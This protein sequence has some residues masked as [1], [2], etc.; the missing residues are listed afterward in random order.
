M[1]GATQ[2]SSNNGSTQWSVTFT[3]APGDTLLVGCNFNTGL[4]LAGVAD[5]AGDAFSQIGTEADSSTTA[6]RAYIASNIRGG[7]TTV[8]CATATAA[9]ANDIYVTELRGVDPVH[10]VDTSV[11]TSGT[12]NPARA[13]LAT[14]HANELAWAYVAA[15]HASD[16]SG[17]TALSTFNGN[18]VADHLQTSPGTV[19]PA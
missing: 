3:P 19:I 8:S 12:R 18:L 6:A 11:S 13:S 16:L 4:S 14:S 5:S 9:A 17:W 2:S 1:V 15:G 7:T 10:P